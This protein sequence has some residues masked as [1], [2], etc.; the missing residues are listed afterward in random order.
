MAEKPTYTEIR[1]F[2]LALQDLGF[3]P[4]RDWVTFTKQSQY[5]CLTVEIAYTA[6]GDFKHIAARARVSFVDFGSRF[7]DRAVFKECKA[8]SLPYV[9]ACEECAERIDKAVSSM[10]EV[11]AAQELLVNPK[12]ILKKEKEA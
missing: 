1:N 2:G 7:P 11:I 6:R 5:T 12:E 10:C 8:L 4:D 3:A 9:R